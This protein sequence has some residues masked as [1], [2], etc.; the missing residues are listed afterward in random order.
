M[1]AACFWLAQL[2]GLVVICLFALDFQSAGQR[3]DQRSVEETGASALQI[4]SNS[5]LSSH[6]S[7]R[8]PQGLTCVIAAQRLLLE[9]EVCRQLVKDPHHLIYVGIPNSTF[10]VTSFG[11]GDRGDSD[12]TF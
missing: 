6:L 5:V 1:S 7:V 9:E 12:G 3:F 2:C 11:D 10:L 8:T 4:A